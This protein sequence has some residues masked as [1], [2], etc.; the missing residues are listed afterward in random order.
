MFAG[1]GELALARGDVAAART[2]SAEC[3]DLATRT[4]S[5]KNLVKGWRLA[6]EIE[7]AQR[8]WDRAEG[9]LR[10]ALALAASLG[11]PVQYW[12][13]EVALGQLLSDVGRPD[14]SRDAYRRAYVRMQQ[15][16][17]SLRDERLRAAFEKSGD[18]RF[19]RALPTL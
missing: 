10:K 14:E 16:R 4:G 5:R 11:N 8:N 2:Y 3:L 6:G 13:T 12:R 17:E 18:L 15:V 7:R 1:M 9:D 19:L